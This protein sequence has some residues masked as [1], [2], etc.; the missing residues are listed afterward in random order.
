ME[1]ALNQLLIVYYPLAIA[2][3]IICAYYRYRVGLKWYGRALIFT[4]VCGNLLLMA[5]FFACAVT[6]LLAYCLLL[7]KTMVIM[8]DYNLNDQL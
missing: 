5:G 8:R 6:L 1:A 4:G 2:G 7:I 3:A